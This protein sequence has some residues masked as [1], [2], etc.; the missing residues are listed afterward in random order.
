LCTRRKRPCCRRAA[1]QRNELA[2]FQ[3]TQLHV[4]LPAEEFVAA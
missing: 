4:L 1:D 3:L 2:P